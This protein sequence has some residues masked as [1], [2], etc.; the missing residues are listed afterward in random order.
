LEN[1]FLKLNKIRGFDMKGEEA[2]AV[3]RK[4]IAQQTGIFVFGLST[5]VIHFCIVNKKQPNKNP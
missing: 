5:R 1:F 2:F 4:K 3:R